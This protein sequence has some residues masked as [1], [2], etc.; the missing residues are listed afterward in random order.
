[1]QK[2]I[3]KIFTRELVGGLL[4]FTAAVL[5]L[6][7][8]NSPLVDAYG[9][10]LS[11]N[12]GVTLGQRGLV[13]PVLLWIND[14]LMV[15]FFL[16]IALEVKRECLEGE[17]STPSQVALPAIG[18]LGG[19]IVP[20]LIYSYFN[21][22]NPLYSHGWAIPT[23][24]DI[25]FVLGVLALL[26]PRVPPGLR[27][28]LLS[29]AI[30]D[31]IGAIL[32]IAFFYSHDL[33]VTMLVGSLVCLAILFA[34]N[35]LG[36]RKL[37]PYMLVGVVMWIFVLK[38]GVHATLTGVALGLMIPHKGAGG[39]NSPLK[40][41][42]YALHPYVVYMILPLF[43][44]TNAGVT[45]GNLTIDDFH[46]TV[47]YGVSLGLF[48]GKQ[49][50]IAAFV[51]VAIRLGFASLPRNTDWPMMYAGCILCGIGFTMSLFIASL[52]FVPGTM[53]NFAADRLGIFIGSFVSGVVGYI[54]ISHCHRR[55]SKKDAAFVDEYSK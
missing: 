16:M 33:S 43:A 4:L 25:A 20:A 51:W 6:L 17:L 19:M 18:A 21:L 23:A 14:G 7:V 39:A 42:E 48:L 34:F 22:G 38:S 55:R 24:T 12:F 9:L 30:F 8:A 36:V 50:G 44:F 54:M 10:L 40:Q 11:T 27:M 41:L 26:G 52:S 1:M 45:L 13:K 46:N 53:D 2:V 32:V 31:D 35:R 3:S 47:T 37:T 15:I 28:F 5:A 29:L 49:L